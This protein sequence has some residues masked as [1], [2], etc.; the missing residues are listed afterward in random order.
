MKDN[1]ILVTVK[2]KLYVS[3]DAADTM[4]LK[5]QSGPLCSGDKAHL[6]WELSWF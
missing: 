1:F 3:Y 2:Q 6:W 5:G 4:E